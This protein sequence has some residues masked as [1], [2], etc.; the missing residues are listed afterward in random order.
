MSV[1][2]G[3]FLGLDVVLVVAGVW[4]CCVRGGRARVDHVMLFSL[5]FTLYWILPVA[6]G[7]TGIYRDQS[8]MSLWY[9]LFDAIGAR[10][11][12]EYFGVCAASYVAFVAGSLVAPAFLAPPRRPAGWGFDRRLGVLFLLPLLAAA[13]IFAYEVRA[14]LFHGYAG[15]DENFGF[16]GSFTAASLFLLALAFVDTAKRHD[17]LGPGATMRALVVT[18][19]FGAY[20]V[21]ALLVLSMGGRLYFMT[22]LLMLL[23]YATVFIAPVRLAT[24][25]G[26]LAGIA[27]LSGVIGLFRLGAGASTAAVLIN[28]LSEFFFTSFSLLNYLSA[29]QLAAVHAPVFLASDFTNLV[30]L[31]L[32]PQKAALAIPPEARGYQVFSP[33]GALNSFFSFQINF[34]VIGT[35][36][37]LFALGAWLSALRVNAQSALARVVYVMVSGW[38]T[39]SFFRDPFSISVVKNIFEFSIVVPTLLVV[40]LY[41]LTLAGRPARAESLA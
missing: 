32:F 27:A 37:V 23:A 5:G 19:C 35:L 29:H 4:G 22:S 10:R 15:I 8:W 20:F 24:F 31:F 7:L 12:A 2:T 17:R 26:S 9:G 6:A 25:G 14:E 40:G 28:L 18:P 39:F 30:P 41:V 3:L 21:F 34:G 38:L 36:V 33:F 16:R 1:F 11:L 13:S